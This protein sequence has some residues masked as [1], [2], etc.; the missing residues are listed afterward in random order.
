VSDEAYIEAWIEDVEDVDDYERPEIQAFRSVVAPAYRHLPTEALE[1]MVA[2]VMEDLPPE[3]AESFWGSLGKIAGQVLPVAAPLLG[4][5]IGGPA[6]GAIGGLVG[7]LA[8][9][10]LGG[11][12]QGGTPRPA[13]PAAAAPA[14][15]SSA[16]AGGGAA[17]QLMQ[18]LQ[19]PALLQSLLGRLTGPTGSSRVPVGS[20]GQSAALGAMMGALGALA[21]QAAIEAA[22]ESDGETLPSYLFDPNGQALCDPAVPLQRAQILVDQL[23]RQV[24]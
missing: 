1:A 24:W 10:L 14:P 13:A 18:L 5:V 23:R 21:N 7:N 2:S 22:A 9:G 8:G 15:T 16:A 17:G 4:S 3:V 19:N 6:G 11:G 20:R 12:G